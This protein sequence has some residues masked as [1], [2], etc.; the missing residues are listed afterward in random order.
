MRAGWLGAAD[1]IAVADRDRQ[2]GPQ[3]AAG[4]FDDR[5]LAGPQVR[6]PVRPGA[7]V[8]ARRD[9]FGLIGREEPR[10][11]SHRVQSWHQVLYVH[12]HRAAGADGR[13][14]HVAR[15]RQAGVQPGPRGRELGLAVAAG[16]PGQVRG[17]RAQHAAG[18]DPQRAVRDGEPLPV[19]RAVE[20]RRAGALTVVEHVPAA[21][22]GSWRHVD[23]DEPDA[24]EIGHDRTSVIRVARRRTP[25]SIWSGTSAL[26][27]SRIAWLPPPF[28]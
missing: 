19:A 22:H 4:R 16:D 27:D 13:R 3:A 15:V 9:V 26:H 6:E 18:Q 1:H 23:R 24:D 2:V 21:G 14:D 10:G 20:G 7:R 12:A 11:Q 8:A 25:S 5:F 17:P 28:R